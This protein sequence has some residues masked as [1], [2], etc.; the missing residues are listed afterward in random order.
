MDAKLVLLIPVLYVALQCAALSRMRDNWQMAAVMPAAFMLLSLGIF[1]LGIVTGASSAAMWLILG[2]PA[3]TIYLVFLLPLHWALHSDSG[4]YA[5]HDHPNH[6]TS[7][8]TG[9]TAKASV[10]KTGRGAKTR[11]SPATR[12]M[13]PPPP[14]SAD[15]GRLIKRASPR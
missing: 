8:G 5:G 9:A 1:V 4:T 7:N 2:L 15:P 12:H 13:P 14:I 6:H 10:S 11:L 3:A